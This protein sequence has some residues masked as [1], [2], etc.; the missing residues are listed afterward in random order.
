[1]PTWDFQCVNPECTQRQTVSNPKCDIEAARPRHCRK[2]MEV[3][4]SGMMGVSTFEPFVTT[5]I[6]PQGIPIKV[7]S[8]SQLRSLCNQYGLNQLDDPGVTMREGKL[9][10]LPKIGVKYFT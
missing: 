10:K 7:T 4:W 3:V 8:R 5:N 6:H 2:P 1:M 9:V